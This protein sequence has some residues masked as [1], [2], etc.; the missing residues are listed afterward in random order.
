MGVGEIYVYGII[1][2][3]SNLD[4]PDKWNRPIESG[5][6]A[7]DFIEAGL[8]TVLRAVDKVEN[9]TG[10]DLLGRRPKTTKASRAETKVDRGFGPEL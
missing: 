10:L 8:D 4:H 6:V 3:M 7:T 9:L 5:D 2:K 1:W